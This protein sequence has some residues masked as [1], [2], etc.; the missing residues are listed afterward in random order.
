[1]PR[2]FYENNPFNAG[3]LFFTALGKRH[4]G[5]APRFNIIGWLRIFINLQTPGKP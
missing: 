4:F 3:R 1:V 5:I 2:F